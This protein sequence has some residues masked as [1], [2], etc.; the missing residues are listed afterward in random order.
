MES[1]IPVFAEE[2]REYVELLASKL[3]S[4]EVIIY[5]NFDAYIN[6]WHIKFLSD[7]I[8]TNY[9]L[10]QPSYK[11]S[12]LTYLDCNPGL[13][14]LA[15]HPLLLTWIKEYLSESVNLPAVE[16]VYEWIFNHWFNHQY[17]KLQKA[18][19]LKNYEEKF[20]E[21]CWVYTHAVALKLKESG[22]D[23]ID[24]EDEFAYESVMMLWKHFFSNE[25]LTHLVAQ[26]CLWHVT[27]EHQLSLYHPDIIGYL[28]SL[29]R[30]D[31]KNYL[32]LPFINGDEGVE[33]LSQLLNREVLAR[34]ST[35]LRQLVADIF[36]GDISTDEY[37]RLVHL[38][39]KNDKFARIA[40]NAITILNAAK[41]PFSRMDLTGIKIPGAYLAEANLDTANLTGAQLNEIGRAH[42]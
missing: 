21:Y 22:R 39:A 32:H 41:V 34:D 20:I 29:I 18:G 28:A 40:A 19:L 17:V 5:D 24:L 33:K 6:Q 15:H 23:S 3:R 1:K 31:L 12:W 9:L 8:I 2:N 25:E 10:N 4:A 11:Q 38:S 37:F 27:V 13:K 30:Y 7:D 14:S 26:S 16:K 36:T 42:V 35:Q